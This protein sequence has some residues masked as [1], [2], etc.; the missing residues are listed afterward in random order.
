MPQ[1]MP[2]WMQNILGKSNI[3]DKKQPLFLSKPVIENPH[4][5]PTKEDIENFGF[6]SFPIKDEKTMRLE[7]LKQEE[8]DEKLLQKQILINQAKG[9][10]INMMF[11]PSTAD[12][13]GTIKI[14]D[15][16]VIDNLTGEKLSD[17]RRMHAVAGRSTIEN[18]IKGSLERGI[19]PYTALAM[20]MQETNLG[21][22]ANPLQNNNLGYKYK[23]EDYLTDRS[24]EDMIND[25]L[26]FLKDKFDYAKKLGKKTDEE[27]IQAWN[28]YG[29]PRSILNNS[30]Y[31]KKTEDLKSMSDEPLYGRKVVNLRDSVIMKNPEIV[32]MVEDAR[33]KKVVVMEF[34]DY[35]K[36]RGGK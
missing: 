6:N 26:D 13:K 14:K 34:K 7:S 1:P 22:L 20:G 25:S 5:L 30:L 3:T 21:M 31:G 8:E 24:P 29:T 33:K 32:K 19:N 11:T 9:K 23:D 15:N 2:Q 35:V 28:G 27:I 18:L 36:Q 16:R 17:K 4:P 10:Y 12:P